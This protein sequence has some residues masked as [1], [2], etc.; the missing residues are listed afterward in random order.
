MSNS[1]HFASVFLTNVVK[2]VDAAKNRVS[3]KL[4]NTLTVLG[5]GEIGAVDHSL[6]TYDQLILE[7]KEGRRKINPGC[8]YTCLIRPDQV[9]T[10][11]KYNRIEEIS[12]TKIKDNIVKYKGFVHKL[13]GAIQLSVRPDGEGEHLFDFPITTKG[14]H[15]TFMAWLMGVP[16][17]KADIFFIS[18]DASYEECLIEEA[19]IHHGDCTDRSNQV[20]EQKFV[21]AVFAGQSDLFE[22][23][24]PEKRAV[25]LNNFLNSLGYY[26]SPKIYG[27]NV[28]VNYEI[29][30]LNGEDSAKK[31]TSHDSIATAC[32]HYTEKV[33]GEVLSAV[34]KVSKSNTIPS[35]FIRAASLFF[36]VMEEPLKDKQGNLFEYLGNRVTPMYFLCKKTKKSSLDIKTDFMNFV[37]NECKPRITFDK[38]TADSGKYKGPELYASRLL[39]LFNQY[40]T[41]RVDDEVFPSTVLQNRRQRFLCS[42]DPHWIYIRS[43]SN[44]AVLGSFLDGIMTSGGSF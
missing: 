12:V 17:I 16:F 5:F 34:H 8:S 15:R 39:W 41:D 42:N 38:I 44:S 40:V 22:S 37:F 7:F 26:V 32:V 11:P 14:N 19:S 13:A 43:L 21:S 35:N 18:E 25:K 23:N 27:M 24:S 30:P 6:P 28:S 29:N 33:V 36:Y 2:V 20:P 31:I 1:K 10:D 3:Q 9:Y 4:K